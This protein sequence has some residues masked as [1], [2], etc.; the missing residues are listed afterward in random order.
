M[1]GTVSPT[2]ITAAAIMTQVLI[3]AI[4]FGGTM[5]IRANEPTTWSYPDR[6]RVGRHLWLLSGFFLLTVLVL[7]F[8]DQFATTWKPLFGDAPFFLIGWSK[9][10]LLVIVLDILYTY[11]IVARTGGALASP[12]VPLYFVLPPLAIFLREAPHRIFGYTLLV[13]LLFTLN[14][15]SSDDDQ[16]P[17]GMMTLAYW[18]VSIMSFFLAT[19]IG[20]ITRPR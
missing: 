13:A 10:L 5:M 14:I 17:A 6:Q 20:Y 16:R 18:F 15:G 4:I 1:N 12:F 9:A 8:S 11:W 2:N 7:V 3:I 19:F